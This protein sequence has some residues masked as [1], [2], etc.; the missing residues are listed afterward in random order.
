MVCR[1]VGSYNS[2]I[3]NI[4]SYVEVVFDSFGRVGDVGGE[5]LKFWRVGVE[6]GWSFEGLELI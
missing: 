4:S 6:F 3:L 1:R 2:H 5:I